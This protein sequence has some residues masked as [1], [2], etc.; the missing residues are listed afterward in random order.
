MSVCVLWPLSI[1]WGW[2]GQGAVWRLRV[3][4]RCVVI[5][6]KT[7]HTESETANTFFRSYVFAFLAAHDGYGL[8]S[9]RKAAA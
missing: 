5:K 8:A 9:D 7:T 2:L 3:M 1:L 6:N 4:T